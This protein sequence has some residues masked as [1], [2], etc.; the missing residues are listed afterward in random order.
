MRVHWASI[1]SK[2]DLVVIVI[3]S[4]LPGVTAGRVQSRYWSSRKSDFGNHRMDCVAPIGHH[5]HE[6]NES[7]GQPRSGGDRQNDL[8]GASAIRTQAVLAG[9]ARGEDKPR[10]RIPVTGIG[11]AS[12][13]DKIP[14]RELS[15]SIEVGNG[16]PLVRAL[17]SVGIGLKSIDGKAI[18]AS[19]RSR[20]AAIVFGGRRKNS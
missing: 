1:T 2:R 15:R 10:R 19:Q 13:Y 7:R 5:N 9:F 3:A 17:G 6:L 14:L 8:H 18:I 20:I 11:N 16:Y 12:G 4:D